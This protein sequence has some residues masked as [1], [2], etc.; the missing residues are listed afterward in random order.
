M[1]E[2]ARIAGTGMSSGTGIHAEFQAFP[3]NVIGNCF[4]AVG[5]F[6]GI[7]NEVA[8]GI[9]LFETPAVVNDDIFI[10]GVFIALFNK[11]V[12][13]F[14]YQCLIDIPCESIP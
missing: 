3:V 1:L 4:H 8:L 11:T 9:A 5:K 12:G 6:F 7:G 10:S 2:T 14:F 13:H